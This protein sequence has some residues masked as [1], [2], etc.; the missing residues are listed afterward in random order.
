MLVPTLAFEAAVRMN[1]VTPITATAIITLI[2][3]AGGNR[4]QSLKEI[5]TLAS[6]QFTSVVLR[7]NAFRPPAL[8]GT[9]GELLEAVQ[10]RAPAGLARAERAERVEP[11][12]REATQLGELRD[13]FAKF[14]EHDIALYAISYDD[15]ETLTEFAEI[16]PTVLSYDQRALGGAQVPGMLINNF[17]FCL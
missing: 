11:R 15:Q 17:N 5:Q 2:L 8:L 1:A 3:L 9:A 4:A 16:Q 7:L 13:A 14:V 6:R 10:P 12:Q